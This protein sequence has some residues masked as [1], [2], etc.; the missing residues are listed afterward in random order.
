MPWPSLLALS[1]LVA[2]MVATVAGRSKRPMVVNHAWSVLL[3]TAAVIAGFVAGGW[4]P[5]PQPAVPGLAR[6]VVTV[7]NVAHDGEGAIADVVIKQGSRVHDRGIIAPGAVLRLRSNALPLGSTA[8]VL[9]TIRSPTGFRNLSPHPDWPRRP[10]VQ[11]ASLASRD[12][13]V[14]LEPSSLRDLIEHTRAHVRR[15]MDR[16]LDRRTAGIARAL[17]LG[18]GRAVDRDDNDVLQRS[19]L[20][21][22]LAVS[23]L[24]VT[25]VCGMLVALLR[26]GLLQTP[27]AR[28][29]DVSRIA[30]GVGIPLCLLYAAFAGGAP[31]AWRAAITTAI[32]WSLTALGRKAAAL[33]VMGLAVLVL[34]SI[35]PYDVVHPGFA[36][37]VA[38]TAAIITMDMKTRSLR[39]WIATSVGLSARA[40]IATLPIVWWCFG[41]IAPLGVVANLVLVPIGSFVLLPLALLHATVATI[42]PPLAVLTALPLEA[43]ASAFVAASSVFV[44]PSWLS[45][46]SPPT[47]LQGVL[48]TAL[49]VG[50]L[51]VRSWRVR[52]ILLSVSAIGLA[53]AEVH[54]RH[55]ERPTGVLRMT[56]ADVGQG[57]GALIDLPDGKLMLLDAGGSPWAGPDPGARALLPLLRARRRDR[58]DLAVLSHPHPDHFGGMPA[59]FGAFPVGSLWDTGQ[60]SI[61]EPNGHAMRIFDSIAHRRI[62]VLRP[63][64]LCNQDLRLGGATARVLWPCPRYDPGLDVNDNSFVIRLSYGE[65][66][67]LL[68][69]DAGAGAER[70]LLASGAP[71]Q[72]DVLKVGHHGSRTSST[73]P[74]LTA[75]RPAVAVVSCGLYNRFG[76]PHAEVIHRLQA[77]GIDVFRTDRDGSV[78]VETDGRSLDIWT[79]SGRDRSP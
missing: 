58:I 3:G 11:W 22:V 41:R 45:E 78:I 17:V 35:R 48:A 32:A 37:S 33:P 57:D 40:S 77:S 34:G 5:F 28:R 8:Q 19:G 24:H 25:I 70:A 65:R 1:V 44:G 23:G 49:C 74:F 18:D 36:L 30:A 26:R 39:E 55:T 72:A 67:F 54:V 6:L 53:L 7:E 51:V 47:A 16:T 50:L 62:R 52:S 9:A 63:R 13:V 60:A 4:G 14:I 71:L 38:A 66:T 46:L 43:T 69:G 2:G 15:Q 73:A 31:S 68:T 21:H 42:T 79:W 27:L 56:F 12:A 75:V 59:L 76:H 29:F 10:M 64:A 20:S 61:E